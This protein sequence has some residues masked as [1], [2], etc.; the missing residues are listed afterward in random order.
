MEE[1]MWYQMLYVAANEQY[2]NI[3]KVIKSNAIEFLMFMNFF[4]KKTKLENNRIKQQ[5]S[6]FN[7]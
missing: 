2:L 3:N 6:V 5:S 4:T 7:K 1:F